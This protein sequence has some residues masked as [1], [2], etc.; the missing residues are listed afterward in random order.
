MIGYLLTHK[1]KDEYRN[2][3][4]YDFESMPK[5]FSFIIC[6]FYDSGDAFYK[7]IDSNIDLRKIVFLEPGKYNRFFN[8]DDRI[9]EV[10][11]IKCYEQY[12]IKY[13]KFRGTF[14]ETDLKDYLMQNE[15]QSFAINQERLYPIVSDKYRDAGNVS[16]YFWQDTWAAKKIMGQKV[17]VHWNVGSRIDGFI[18]ILLSA[19]KQVNL[20]DVRPLPILIDGLA[21]IQNDATKLSSIR[22]D[23]ISSFL[24]LCSLEHFGLGRYGDPINPRAWKIIIECLQNKIAPNGDVFISVPVGAQRVEFNAHRVFNAET[25]IKEFNKCELVEYSAIYPDAS[26][27]DYNV[28]PDKYS[29]LEETYVYGLFWFRKK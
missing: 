19:G 24:A 22:D 25:I 9:R 26:G 20:I 27:I 17:S 5:D 10:L 2:L 29:N 18:S 12:A 13:G 4:V 1:D 28:F 6:A 8:P 16:H 14:F 21:F 15:D 11:S 7:L 23:C 3:P